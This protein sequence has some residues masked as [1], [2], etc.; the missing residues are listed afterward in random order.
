MS[1]TSDARDTAASIYYLK[2]LE[3]LR[4]A[5]LRQSIDGDDIPP[6]FWERGEQAALD[7]TKFEYFNPTVRQFFLPPGKANS[8]TDEEDFAGRSTQLAEMGTYETHRILKGIPW[9]GQPEYD[10]I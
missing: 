6:D 1:F 10:D 3:G 5:H 7:W 8:L 4:E 2:A 9:V